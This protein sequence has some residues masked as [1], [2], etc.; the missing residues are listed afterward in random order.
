[1]YIVIEHWPLFIYLSVLQYSLREFIPMRRTVTRKVYISLIVVALLHSWLSSV[2]PMHSYWSLLCLPPAPLSETSWSTL[3]QMEMARSIQTGTHQSKQQ[4]QEGWNGWQPS[5][6]LRTPVLHPLSVCLHHHQ[7]LKRELG[8]CQW[9]RG[10]Q[11]QGFQW[12]GAAPHC[13]CQNLFPDFHTQTHCQNFFKYPE[14][15][16]S[17]KDIANATD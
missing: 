17:L 8:L 3:P 12:P 2:A 14:L 5:S 1:M 10:P 11:I 16:S 4:G 13:H 15:P 6:Y 9:S 7:H